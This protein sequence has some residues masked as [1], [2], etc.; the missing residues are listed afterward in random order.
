MG[1]LRIPANW[2]GHRSSDPYPGH[3][4]R[5]V[6]SYLW[7]SLCRRP[8]YGVESM[9]HAQLVLLS[10]MPMSPSQAPL[11]GVDDKMVAAAELGGPVRGG[12]VVG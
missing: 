8:K 9:E 1:K 5:A 11:L 4:Q 2:M 7:P 12:E 6:A 10:S 3:M